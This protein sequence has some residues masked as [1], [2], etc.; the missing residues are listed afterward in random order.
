MPLCHVSLPGLG[1]EPAQ[2]NPLKSTEPGNDHGRE[3]IIQQPPRRKQ[4]WTIDGNQDEG[5][6]VSQAITATHQFPEEW[7]SFLQP[8]PQRQKGLGLGYRERDRGRR[9]G[10]VNDQF[11]FLRGRN[12]LS[13]LRLAWAAA[14]AAGYRAEHV[15]LGPD[16]CEHG[17]LLVVVHRKSCWANYC[18][19]L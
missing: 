4:P 5:H 16:G 17:R 14:A 7:T 19:S 6:P 13:P 1:H 2:N 11:H 3:K 18:T 15:L 10:Q 9:K 8:L 12:A